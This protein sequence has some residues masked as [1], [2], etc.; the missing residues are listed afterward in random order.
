VIVHPTKNGYTYEYDRETGKFL[1]AFAYSAPNWNKGIDDYGKPISPIVPKELKEGLVCPSIH[2]GGRGIQHSAYSPRTGWWYSS[3]FELCTHFVDG[4]DKGDQLNPNVPPNIS[5]FDPATG[6]K[7][8]T[9]DT[10]YYNMSSLLATAGDL[11]FGGDL[12]GNVFA[13]D[14]K[15]GKKLW[16]F[17]TGGRIASAA[18]SYSVDGRQFIAIGS[19]GG[20]ETEGRLAK[21][22][23]EAAAHIAQPTS[24]LFVFALPEK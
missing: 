23:P 8:W 18:V 17:N 2:T 10:K 3:D 1:R 22:Y 13:L 6:K 24:T 15:T 21:I 4:G 16:S 14:A 19:G 5:A 7:E 9:F 12:E 20:S 11:I